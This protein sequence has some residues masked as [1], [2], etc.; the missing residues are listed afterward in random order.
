MN[1]PQNI[2]MNGK[3]L[4]SDC[5]IMESYMAWCLAILFNSLQTEQTTAE[6]LNY[7]ESRS[8]MQKS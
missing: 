8:V 6:M 5:V 1:K 2:I 3:T 7:V 4:L